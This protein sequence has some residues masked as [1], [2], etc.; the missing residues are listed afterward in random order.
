MAANS[1]ANHSSVKLN[2]K[3]KHWSGVMIPAMIKI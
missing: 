3:K 1:S 2:L